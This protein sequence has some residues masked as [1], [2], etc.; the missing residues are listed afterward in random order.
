MER[1]LVKFLSTPPPIDGI[2]KAG[3][4]AEAT[5]LGPLKRHDGE[6]A[7][8]ATR[9]LLG[10]D[11]RHLYLAF[12]LVDDD[13]WGTFREDGEA[14]YQEEVVEVFLDPLGTGVRYFEIEVS[15]HN[16]VLTGRNYWEGRTLRFEQ[17]WSCPGLVTRV[18]VEG[19][20]DDPSDE[21]RGWAVTMAIPFEALGVAPPG[22][23]DAWRANLYRIDRSRR[24]PGD[25]FQAWS[26]TQSAGE[27]PDF[28]VPDRFG[29]VEF[30]G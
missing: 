20:V 9:A 2:G 8:Q 7:R 16:A 25:E 5:R 1:L 10:Y 13:V 3:S 30:S 27:P 6:A 22:P 29:R 12:Q 4:W 28:N 18:T 17:D 21:D 19:S 23:G 14:L 26:P 24:G 15:P 11:E